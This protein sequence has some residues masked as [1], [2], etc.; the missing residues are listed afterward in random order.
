MSPRVTRP[1]YCRSMCT[2]GTCRCVRARASIQPGRAWRASAARR[3]AHRR[4]GAHLPGDEGTA[5]AV[6]P[7]HARVVHAGEVRQADELP[8]ACAHHRQACDASAVAR[9]SI[10]PSMHLAARHAPSRPVWL[11][12][13]LMWS[14]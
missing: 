5:G 9:T 6:G 8:K 13:P 1:A 11:K 10:H 7:Q 3:G 12:S 4:R 14:G 2:V